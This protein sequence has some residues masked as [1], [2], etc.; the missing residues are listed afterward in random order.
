[1]SLRQWLP[2]DRHDLFDRVQV[3]L[4][5]YVEIDIIWRHARLFQNVVNQGR[6]VVRIKGCREASDELHP[7]DPFVNLR[8]RVRL[9]DAA[10]VD[11]QRIIIFAGSDQLAGD[12]PRLVTRAH[13]HGA[14]AVGK[15]SAGPVIGVIHVAAH[16]IGADH[17]DPIQRRIGHQVARRRIHGSD[18]AGAGG[19]DVEGARIIRP[20]LGL[21]HS[22]R[23]RADVIRRVGGDDNQ[24]Q[25]VRVEP[26]AGQRLP[27]SV[28]T[29]VAGA[30][31]RGHDVALFDADVGP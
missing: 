12:E 23:R 22:R 17:Q 7:W 29:Q 24:I 9:G 26:G 14:R 6:P 8:R 21:Q 3:E 10:G 4:G 15:K 31:V 2:D 13:D 25:I 27:G 16:A 20:Q 28:F 11:S 19:V 18:P 30:F 5:K 1:M